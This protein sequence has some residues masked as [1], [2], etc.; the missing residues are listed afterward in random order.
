MIVSGNHYYY[1]K[2][3][4]GIVSYGV[5]TALSSL[6]YIHSLKHNLVRMREVNWSWAD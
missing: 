2:A 6:R 3:E 4:D 5:Y 1:D